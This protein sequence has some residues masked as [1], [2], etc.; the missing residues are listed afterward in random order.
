MRKEREPP[1]RV[2][3]RAGRTVI[4]PRAAARP[5]GSPPKGRGGRATRAGALR[6]VKC[7]GPMSG[8]S[9]SQA[10]GIETAAPGRARVE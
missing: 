4:A 8:P 6:T 2:P 10:S 7:A 3:H 9:S 1:G 5:C